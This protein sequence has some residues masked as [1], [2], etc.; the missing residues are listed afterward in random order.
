MTISKEQP[1]VYKRKRYNNMNFEIINRH[2]ITQMKLK[3]D[4]TIVYLL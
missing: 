3:S 2:I 1:Y 4:F